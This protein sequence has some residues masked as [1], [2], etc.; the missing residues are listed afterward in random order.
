MLGTGVATRRVPDGS[1]ITV[2]GDAGTVTLPG[3]TDQVG[4]A[5][6]TDTA[7]SD[8]A[9]RARAAATAA[10]AAGTAAVVW[11]A[12]RARPHRH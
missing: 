9:R 7:R 10:A 5:A 12:R 6:T 11:R 2:N 1:T 4:E 8:R 3:A